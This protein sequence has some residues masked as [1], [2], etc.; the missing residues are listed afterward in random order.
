MG[1]F[2]YYIYNNKIE[3]EDSYPKI[4]N[5]H[6]IS[7]KIQEIDAKGLNH[8][9]I[10]NLADNIRKEAKPIILKNAGNDWNALHWTPDYLKNRIID[11]HNEDF[12]I[13][14]IYSNKNNVFGPLWRN[15]K[16][17]ARALETDPE[18]VKIKNINP[19]QMID[20]PVKTFFDKLKNN[21]TDYLHY[22]Y[23]GDLNTKSLVKDILLGVNDFITT[24]E[25]I[26][27]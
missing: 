6:I 26:H 18:Y 25:K 9:E 17:L 4:F 10:K 11:E 3:A 23:T 14:N 16:F 5:S 22:Y 27:R 15:Q 12:I 21:D 13:Q 2:F 1:I 20:L 19:H 7:S 8:I 24:G